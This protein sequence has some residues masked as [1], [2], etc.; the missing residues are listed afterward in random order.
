MRMEAEKERMVKLEKEYEELSS[1]TIEYV[2]NNPQVIAS[3]LKNWRAPKR[4][5]GSLEANF[6][7]NGN[8]PEGFA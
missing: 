7:L 3:L 6:S 1:Y 4:E 5:E 2:K 8:K